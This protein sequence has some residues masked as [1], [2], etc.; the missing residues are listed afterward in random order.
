MKSWKPSHLI[1]EQYKEGCPLSP[2][3]FNVVLEVLATAI[4]QE[5]DIKGIQIGMEEVKLS[6]FAESMI[7]GIL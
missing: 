4:R 5:E 6:L 7:Q 2:L 1:Q 3:S